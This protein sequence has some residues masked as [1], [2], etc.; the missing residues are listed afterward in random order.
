VAGAGD[1][2]DD[3]Q[4]TVAA[5]TAIVSARTWC[6]HPHGELASRRI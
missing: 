3:L 4:P 2:S 6:M 1:D 5:A